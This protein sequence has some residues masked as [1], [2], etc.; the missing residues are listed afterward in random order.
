MGAG[1]DG[2]RR[3]VGAGIASRLRLW[4]G[5]GIRTVEPGSLRGWVRRRCRR[6]VWSRSE[7][8]AGRR[9]PGNTQVRCRART[10][11][12]WDAV[13][14]RRTATARGSPLSSMTVACHRPSRC[15]SVTW[16]AMSAT[17]GPHPPRSPGCSAN[18]NRVRRSTVRSTIP[19]PNGLL[20]PGGGRRR[21]RP[22]ADPCSARHRGACGPG[23]R[24][25]PGRLPPHPAAGPTAAG[26]PNPTGSPPARPCGPRR[27]VGAGSWRLR[28]RPPDTAC[29]TGHAAGRWSSRVPGRLRRPPPDAPLRRSGGR[30]R[31]PA[32]GPGAHRP[33][34]DPAAHRPGG[35]ARSHHERRR[36]RVGRRSGSTATPPPPRGRRTP[37]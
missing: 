26:W 25:V 13:G 18:P 28:G 17:T 29:A 11:R 1:P 36:P 22:A 23:S 31:P 30:C 35:A 33:D 16:R 8:R 15:R 6:R 2:G 12:A 19:R 21:R 14:R 24:C 3:W 27:L 32:P 5:G 37:R 34:L 7:D 10:W 9:H 4:P 20:C